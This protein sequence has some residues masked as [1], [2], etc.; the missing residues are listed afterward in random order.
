MGQ[1]GW[2]RKLWRC[3]FWSHAGVEQSTPEAQRSYSSTMRNDALGTGHAQSMIDSPQAW[4]AANNV[5]GEY[6]TIALAGKSRVMGVVSQGRHDYN[7]WVKSYSIQTSIDGVT[8]H[9]YNEG[10]VFAANY[11]RDTKVFNEFHTA[12]TAQYVRLVVA[13]WDHYISMRADVLLSSNN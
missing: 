4:S 7:Q 3:E 5:V 2:H 6:L 11:D 12:V 8:F 10:Q 13:T 1:S 9:D